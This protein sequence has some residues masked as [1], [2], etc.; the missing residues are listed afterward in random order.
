MNKNKFYFSLIILVFCFSLCTSI[1]AAE[2]D[3]PTKSHRITCNAWKAFDDKEYELVYKYTNDCFKDFSLLAE[4][5][6]ALLDAFPAKENINNYWA[7]N[8]VA[9]CLFIKG[10]SLREQGKNKEALEIFRN[11]IFN[12]PHAQCWDPIGWYWKVVEGARDQILGL[13]MD[14]DFENCTSLILRKKALNAFFQ[15]EYVKAYIYTSKCISLYSK[16]ADKMQKS[17]TAFAPKEKA[18]EYYALNDVAMCHLIQGK[19]LL[20]KNKPKRA[21]K[22]FKKIIDRFPFA[23][24]F[25]SD[26]A[27]FSHISSFAEMGLKTALNL[28]EKE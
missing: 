5:Q 19:I 25:H 26:R 6:Q 27:E 18:Y 9:T 12:Y 10:R 1:S 28:K 17:L 23:Q 14:I 20:K 21:G 13:R 2:V 8:N 4:K 22:I 15:G 7:L 11:I 16:E 3:L 24:Y